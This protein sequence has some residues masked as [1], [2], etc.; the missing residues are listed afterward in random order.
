M[1]GSK[2][3][4]STSS[5]HQAPRKI[6]TSYTVSCLQRLIRVTLTTIR[7][8]YQSGTGGLLNHGDFWFTI[9]DSVDIYQSDLR[10][11]DLGLVRLESGE[12]IPTDVLLCGTGWLPSLDFFDTDLL[13]KLD[14]P[15]EIAH[16]PAE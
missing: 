12:E 15:H 9:T 3:G 5:G 13:I 1:G 2:Q 10:E 11:L 6:S 16:E 14:L 7:I 8:F 4:S